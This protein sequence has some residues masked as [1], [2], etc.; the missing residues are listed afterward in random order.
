MIIEIFKV[1]EEGTEY[2][3][4][5]PASIIDLEPDSGVEIIQPVR[6]DLF[7][8]LLGNRLVVRGTLGTQAR[9]ACCRCG[10]SFEQSVKVPRFVCVRDFKNKSESAD[11]TENIREDTILAFPSFPVCGPDCRGLCLRCGVNLNHGACQCGPPDSDARWC[12]LDGLK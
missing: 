2:V 9:F 1:P 8:Q 5:E 7:A 4:E 3:G 12:A 11:L 6:Y 10:E